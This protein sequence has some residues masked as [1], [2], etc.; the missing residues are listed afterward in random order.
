MWFGISRRFYIQPKPRPFLEFSWAAI[1][2]FFS[3]F[4]LAT[5]AIFVVVYVL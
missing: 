1:R 4:V 5:L 3:L 2:L